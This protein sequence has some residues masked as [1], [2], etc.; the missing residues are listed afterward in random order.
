MESWLIM[1]G[2]CS[3]FYV[4]S[5][6]DFQAVKSVWIRQNVTEEPLGIE[7]EEQ[8]DQLYAKMGSAN[9]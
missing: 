7:S 4:S 2:K 9:A 3:D 8:L 5:M 1:G 6:Y